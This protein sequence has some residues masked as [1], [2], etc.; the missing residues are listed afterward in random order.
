MSFEADCPGAPAASPGI[1][2]CDSTGVLV[3]GVHLGDGTND[4]VA[5]TVSI[6]SSAPVTVSAMLE[7]ILN[8]RDCDLVCFDH[9][10]TVPN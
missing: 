4:T 9:R 7:R 8:S 2:S 5:L 1:R 3:T 10:G 6:D